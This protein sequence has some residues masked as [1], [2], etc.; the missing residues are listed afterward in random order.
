MNTPQ[1]RED[2]F[3]QRYFA[4]LAG[5]GA[6]G[7]TDDAA[8]ITVPAGHDLVVS[9]DTLLSNVHFF[10]QDPPKMLAQKALRVSLSDL[11]AKGAEPTGYFLSLG[12]PSARFAD[13]AWLADFANGLAEDQAQYGLSLLGGD[14]VKTDQN[15]GGIT[16]AILAHGL[17]PSGRMVRRDGA[18][19]GDVVLVSGTIGDAA[20][21]LLARK[22][23][24]L[25]TDEPLLGGL[26][27]NEVSSL[28]QAYL[29][30]KPEMQSAPALRAYA[31]A[32]MD[33]SDGL[34]GDANSL[35]RASGVG[36]SLA[37][38][39]VPHSIDVSSAEQRAHLLSGGDDY[40]ILCTV[41]ANHLDAFLQEVHGAWT[42]IGSVN[43]QEG[44]QLLDMDE[45]GLT[46]IASSFDHLAV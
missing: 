34:L 16:I 46:D 44:V 32:A 38:A 3:I 35:A 29:M 43:S 12:L 23:H 28:E 10:P 13:A 31:S 17:V 15:G 30:P 24:L 7:L 22:R 21:G 2:A 9:T 25:G 36:V 39:Q 11:A 42:I 14:T 5:E 4:P 45:L 1:K 6:F 26:S 33:I 20:L 27:Q 19:P 40:Q 37:A 41:P 8:A 18:K